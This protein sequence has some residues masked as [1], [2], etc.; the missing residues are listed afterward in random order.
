MKLK[1]NDK[2]PLS[3]TA[4]TMKGSGVGHYDGMAVFVP[5]T[6][7]GDEITAHIVKI[8]SNYAFARMDELRVASPERVAPDCPVFVLCGGCAFRHIGYDTELAI[9]ANHVKDALQRIGHIDV[10]PRTHH[11]RPQPRPLPQQGAV[12]IGKSRGHP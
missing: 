9:K 12:S 11:R 10:A 4:V 8:K 3:I 2:I 7:T 1:K 5:N 6:V